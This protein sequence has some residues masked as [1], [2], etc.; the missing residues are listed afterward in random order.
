MLRR[1]AARQRLRPR[2]EEG[3]QIDR[4]NLLRDRRDQLLQVRKK[5]I[6]DEL[7][8]GVPPAARRSGCLLPCDNPTQAN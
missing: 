3:M 7:P 2:L 1:S 5:S 4:V 8:G 6:A